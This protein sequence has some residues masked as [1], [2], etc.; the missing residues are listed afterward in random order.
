MAAFR[1]DKCD[2][3]CQCIPTRD[4]LAQSKSARYDTRSRRS[5]LIRQEGSQ[6]AVEEFRKAFI[7]NPTDL[8]LLTFADE[9]P[10]PAGLSETNPPLC[11]ETLVQGRMLEFQA[12]L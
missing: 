7:K 12:L 3:I 11:R 8:E 10:H 5:H 4:F 1:E 2:K 6:F 9:R